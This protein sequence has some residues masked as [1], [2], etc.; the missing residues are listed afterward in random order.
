[1]KTWLMNILKINRQSVFYRILI[2]TLIVTLL[3]VSI[4][5]IS[6]YYHSRDM[7]QNQIRMIDSQLLHRY[8]S[9]VDVASEQIKNRAS[10]L[11]DSSDIIKFCFLP[12]YSDYTVLSRMIS[13]LSSVSL[14]DR[15]ISSIYVYSS[16]SGKLLTSDGRY[17]SLDDFN[18]K[19]WF[20]ESESGRRSSFW[21]GIRDLEDTNRNNKQ[22][23]SLI[24]HVPAGSVKN[25]GAVVVNLSIDDF[26][27]E[28]LANNIPSGSNVNIYSKNMT[29][30]SGQPLLSDEE[31]RMLQSLIEQENS[32]S[33][34]RFIQISGEQFFVTWSYLS[35]L[36]CYLIYQTPVQIRAKD[37][38]NITNLLIIYL[39][40]FILGLLL[41]YYA[42][43]KIYLPV[44]SLV[45][46]VVGDHAAENEYE[47]LHNRYS[48]IQN[49]NVDM[50]DRLNNLKPILVERFFYRHIH[51]LISSP[52]NTLQ[53]LE[54][55]FSQ[56]DYDVIIL[57]YTTEENELARSTNMTT[58]QIRE[59]VEFLLQDEPYLS[60]CLENSNHSICVILNF[61]RRLSADEAQQEMI[62]ISSMLRKK[63]KDTLQIDITTGF[64]TY[65][66]TLDEIPSSYQ[67]A[68]KTVQFKLYHNDENFYGDNDVLTSRYAVHL[69]NIREELSTGTPNS[70]NGALSNLLDTVGKHRAELTP[71]HLQQISAHVLNTMMECLIDHRLQAESV[72]GKRDLFKELYERDSFYAMHKYLEKVCQSAYAAIQQANNKASHLKVTRIKEYIE[73]H[74][75]E[76]ISLNDVAEWINLSPAYVS[77]IFKEETGETFVE[78]ISRERITRAKQL[79]QSTNLSIKDVG[80]K[81]GFNNMQTFIRTFKRI[82]NCTPSQ[83]AAGIT[84]T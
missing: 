42:S 35:E 23:L 40:V 24:A 34:S 22:G 18:D 68:L 47:L 84:K 15:F 49:Q 37:Y 4:L 62:R 75:T 27:N 73:E 38:F 64:G 31:R 80:F 59:L 70:L 9:T 45:T 20:E 7:L 36:Q 21:T 52:E 56:T 14:Q 81:C 58:L 51:G 72:F 83:Y 3:P 16:A 54:S 32:D 44:D 11:A 26:F 10:S 43:K 55:A 39:A 74:L 65:C 12:D 6:I 17:Y 50:S 82:E 71:L 29:P 76:D 53:S 13:E 41:A 8:Q 63:V 61:N 66:N 33:G 67:I 77:R 28:I 5:Y 25:T 19:G 2:L 57:Q 1:M 69:E 48:Q 79:L 78:Y 60:I 46:T 30:L